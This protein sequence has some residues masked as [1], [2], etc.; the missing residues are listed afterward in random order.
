VAI[1]NAFS[2]VDNV[3]MCT[4]LGERKE[5]WR[6]NGTFRSTP[7]SLPYEKRTPHCSRVYYIFGSLYSF[8]NDLF[9]LYDGARFPLVVHAQHFALQHK[10]SPLTGHGEGFDELEFPLAVY[11]PLVVEVGHAW[12]GRGAAAGVKVDGL[13]IGTFKREN[14]R[15]GWERGE[16]WMQ[17]LH[18]GKRVSVLLLQGMGKKRNMQNCHGLTLVKDITTI[19]KSKMENPLFRALFPVAGTIFACTLGRKTF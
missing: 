2:M 8:D 10:V 11:D 14:D 18:V 1:R 16:V 5:R 4:V 9:G 3:R 17:F 7:T 13:L 12:D 6:E 15:V 19:T